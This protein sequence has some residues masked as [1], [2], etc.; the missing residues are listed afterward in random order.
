MSHTRGT[1]PDEPPWKLHNW[2]DAKWQFPHRHGC[3]VAGRAGVSGVGT[4]N[5]QSAMAWHALRGTRG[6]EAAPPARAQGYTNRQC[7]GAEVALGTWTGRRRVFGR[8]VSVLRSGGCV[9]PAAHACS[10][11]CISGNIGRWCGQR[12]VLNAD[13]S[14]ILL[15]P[16]P[17]DI[18]HPPMT[19][20]VV[21]GGQRGA[22]SGPQAPPPRRD[23]D[24]AWRWLMAAPP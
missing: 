11:R 15:H 13:T 8:F 3:T 5:Q 14:N 4:G 24:G 1:D 2:Q 10:R 18:T 20:P 21:A 16:V 9:S 6:V 17:K 22:R 12:H 23:H 19:P 7:R